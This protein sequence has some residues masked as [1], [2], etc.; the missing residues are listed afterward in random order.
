MTYQVI[1]VR[2]M[3][4]FITR[5]LDFSGGLGEIWYRGHRYHYYHVEPAAYRYQRFRLASKDVEDGSLMAARSS[6]LHI[7]DTQALGLDLDWLCYLQHNGLPTRLL[8]WTFEFQVALYFAF[9]D[10]IRNR[11][12][13]GGFPCVWAI[14]P[15]AF[16]QALIDFMTKQKNAFGIKAAERK[17]VTKMLADKEPKDT[18]TISNFESRKPTLLDDLYIPFFSP[19][20]NE[21]AKMQGGCFIRFPLLNE[22]QEDAFR[23]ARL[24]NFVQSDPCFSGCMAKFVF[25]HPSSMVQD[26]SLLNFKVSRIYPEVENIA[27][28]LRNKFFETI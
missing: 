22:E 23:Q 15:K 21:R 28:G 14:K 16:I 19:Y 17:H 20:V 7:P 4:E 25:I 9:E 12:K 10:Y 8:D 26:L 11:T 5:L 18:K 13:P 1:V 2:S 24:E 3:P 6:M 27:L